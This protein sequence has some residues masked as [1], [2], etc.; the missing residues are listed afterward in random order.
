M[1]RLFTDRENL[2]QHLVQGGLD[3]LYLPKA[4]KV[5]DPLLQSLLRFWLPSYPHNMTFPL[6]TPRFLLLGKQEKL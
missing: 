3:L 6:A 5:R 1:K 4:R 2:Q